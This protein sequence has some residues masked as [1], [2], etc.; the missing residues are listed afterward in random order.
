MRENFKKKKWYIKS[1]YGKVNSAKPTTD[2]D[3]I[4]LKTDR[5]EEHFALKDKRTT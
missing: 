5:N 3:P 1:S 4:L 2:D